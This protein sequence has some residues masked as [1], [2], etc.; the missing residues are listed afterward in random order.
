MT[1][2][3]GHLIKEWGYTDLPDGR[4]ELWVIC[5]CGVRLVF[6]D[7]SDTTWKLHG[8]WE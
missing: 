2:H 1:H 7:P 6:Y 3:R 8:H 5:T 4:T